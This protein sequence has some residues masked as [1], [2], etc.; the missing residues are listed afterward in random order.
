[1]FVSLKREE[2]VFNSYFRSQILITKSVVVTMN[3]QCVVQVIE[4]HA[5]RKEYAT[6]LR[7]WSVRMW[8]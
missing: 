1:M 6:L 7:V 5:G 3:V 4:A 2:G 8:E